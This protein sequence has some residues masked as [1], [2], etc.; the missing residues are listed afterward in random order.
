M[1][2]YEGRLIVVLICN[3]P[4][5]LC[6]LVKMPPAV[7]DRDLVQYISQKTDE[8]TDTTTILYRNATHPSRPESRGI[9]RWAQN[10][11]V[12]NNLSVIILRC[13]FR[14]F[15]EFTSACSILS[16]GSHVHS[17]IYHVRPIL[18]H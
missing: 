2:L 12:N 13:K 3:V 7:A 16:Q 14:M 9:V 17:K 6:R 5:A 11:K 4:N 10:R 18:Q 1:Y 8:S 15:N